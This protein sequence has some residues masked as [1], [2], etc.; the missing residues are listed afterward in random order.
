[1]TSALVEEDGGVAAEGA[2]GRLAGR[3]ALGADA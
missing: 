1:V 2:L 3:V